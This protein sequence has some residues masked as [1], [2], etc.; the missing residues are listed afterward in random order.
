MRKIVPDSW[1]VVG[2]VRYSSVISVPLLAI[3]VDEKVVYN[4][5]CYEPLIFT[6]Q[7]AHWMPDMDKNFRI[8]V[9]ATFGEM[10]KAAREQNAEACAGLDTCPAD[11]R[12]T[13]AYFE[14]FMAEAVNAAARYDVPL[15]CGEYGVIDCARP[16]DAL[17]WF[18]LIHGAFEKYGI[19]RAA[20][21]YREMD[22]GL[23]DARMDGV[24]DELVKVL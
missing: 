4:F 3:P 21:S 5:H 19:G 24:R 1:L 15:Y 6:H 20:W 17:V 2:G 11:T 9:S 14:Q 16:E 7:A 12:L 13:T 23:S 8:S 22:F 18:T 10:Y